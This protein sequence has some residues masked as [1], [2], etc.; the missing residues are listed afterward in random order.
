MYA[1]IDKVLRGRMMRVERGRHAAA[2]LTAA[3]S[4][5]GGRR[6]GAIDA[7]GLREVE[8][9]IGPTR[10]GGGALMGRFARVIRWRAMCPDA[11]WLQCHG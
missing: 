8:R 10:L 1:V 6:P 4:G 5:D 2:A 9:V 7:H 3:P 11:P